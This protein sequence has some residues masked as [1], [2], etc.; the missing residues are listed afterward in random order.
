V[1]LRNGDEISSQ[2]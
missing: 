2:F 1:A